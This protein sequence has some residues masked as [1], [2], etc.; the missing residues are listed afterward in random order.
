MATR[1]P[2]SMWRPRYTA[3]MPPLPSNDSILYW[4]SRTVPTNEEGSSSRTSPSVGQ[5]LNPS[6]NFSLQT[7]QY[8]IQGIFEAAH[9][10]EVMTWFKRAG[11]YIQLRSDGLVYHRD[12]CTRIGAGDLAGTGRNWKDDPRRNTKFHEKGGF[13]VISWIAFLS[14]NPNRF[15]VRT[16][17][18]S[19][20]C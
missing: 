17:R 16:L 7:V 20:Y 5:K 11:S 1:S 6:S 14:P 18:P 4:P 13:R 8:F 3:P 12:C 9:Q 19:D 10:I 15:V 2:S